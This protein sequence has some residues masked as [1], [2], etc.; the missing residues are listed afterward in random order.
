MRLLKGLKGSSP[1]PLPRLGHTT[2]EAIG[3]WGEGLEDP[4]DAEA[5]VVYG[6]W[7]DLLYMKVACLFLSAALADLA[8]WAA[9]GSV[10][11]LLGP[12]SLLILCLMYLDR[13]R[14]FRRTVRRNTHGPS[15]PTVGAGSNVRSPDRATG[16]TVP[17]GTSS[18]HRSGGSGCHRRARGGG[19]GGGGGKRREGEEREGGR[20]EGGGKRGGGGG[21]RREEGGGGGGGRGGKGGEEEA[22]GEAAQSE[23]LEPVREHLDLFVFARGMG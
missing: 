8:L 9:T 17:A 1:S 10:T 11:S 16:A 4:G 6:Q 15:T 20:R 13:R 14:R 3:G 5:A 2:L 7:A 18:P 23:P 19:E 12:G 22:L 21:R